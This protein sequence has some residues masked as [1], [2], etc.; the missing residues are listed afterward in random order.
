M[1]NTKS[2]ILSLFLTICL[3]LCSLS[4]LFVPLTTVNAASEP[5][6]PSTITLFSFLK[7]TSYDKIYD[8][9]D[10]ISEQSA[11]TLYIN[12]SITIH[13]K[14]ETVIF[15]GLAEN[16]TTTSSQLNSLGQEGSSATIE[17]TGSGEA[18]FLNV[19]QSASGT[20]T[21]YSIRL[22]QT[23]TNF[24]KTN[25][26]SWSYKKDSSDITLSAP[27]KGSIYPSLT[28][29]LNYEHN[30][31]AS[32]NSPLTIDMTYN[33]Q[34]YSIINNGTEFIA[35]GTHFGA[36]INSLVF[37]APGPYT[38]E[39][40]D[41][42][43]KPSKYNNN[44]NYLKYEFVI[45]PTDNAYNTFK[46]GYSSFYYTLQTKTNDGSIGTYLPVGGADAGGELI[47]TNTSVLLTLHNVDKVKDFLNLSLQTTI[48]N[49]KG[50]VTNDTTIYNQNHFGNNITYQIPL[51]KHGTYTITIVNGSDSMSDS[52]SDSIYKSILNIYKDI[53]FDH[54]ASGTN[55]IQT[56]TINAEV[57][58]SYRFKYSSGDVAIT[59]TQTSSADYKTVNAKSSISGIDN[60]ESS[61]QMVKLTINGVGQIRVDTTIDGSTSTMYVSDGS[62]I[63]YSESGTYYVKITDEMGNVVTRSFKISIQMNTAS[64][65]LIIVG[66]VL[67]VA[68]VIIIVFTRR[69]VRVR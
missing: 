26:F 49:D 56:E 5:S 57:K 35:H 36:S 15:Y 61:S 53:V 29:T 41:G 43:Y 12:S 50:G 40:Y 51:D 67:L 66:S 16:K 39:I 33:G 1:K 54:S 45:E 37:S 63:N 46:S 4:F 28:A 65:I 8:E 2:I 20:S 64:L 34:K 14:T 24:N 23:K 31:I 13:N 42:T 27:T 58:T 6:Q 32:S 11:P 60:N 59:N 68:L 17:Y 22:I 44:Q 48:S 10:L 52:I 25:I 30:S 38:I 18:Q 69:K 19:V 21:F 9:T 3:G 62:T 47:N 55:V 7:I